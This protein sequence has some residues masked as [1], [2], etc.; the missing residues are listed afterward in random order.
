MAPP[1][2]DAAGE[3]VGDEGDVDEAG[4]GGDVGEVGDPAAV[5]GRGDEVAVDQ[6]AG[7]VRRARPGTVVRRVLPRI[8][9]VI[10]SSRISRSTVQRATASPRGCSCRQILR[11]P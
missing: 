9:P 3:Q 8:A 1:A 6:V 2:D 4:P 10:P 11:A 5:G 7:P